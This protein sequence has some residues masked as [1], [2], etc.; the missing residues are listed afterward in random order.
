[1]KQDRDKD[2]WVLCIGRFAICGLDHPLGENI[3]KKCC[4]CGEHVTDLLLSLLCKYCW[5]DSVCMASV[6][7]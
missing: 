1:M 6:L 4:G 3:W 5:S 2:N 7:D